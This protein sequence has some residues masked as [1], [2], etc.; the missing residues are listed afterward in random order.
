MTQHSGHKNVDSLQSDKSA[1]KEQI[2]K[3]STILS[4]EKAAS[5]STSSIE[6]SCNS[7]NINIYKSNTVT[8]NAL[9]SNTIRSMFAGAT[10]SGN[11]TFNIYYGEPEQKTKKNCKRMNE[12]SK[13]YHSHKK[14]KI[15][16]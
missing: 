2:Y 12:L 8:E 15:Q 5:T 10:F 3:M 14:N 16:F 7:D 9:H 13:L 1:N 6:S 4:K 11:C